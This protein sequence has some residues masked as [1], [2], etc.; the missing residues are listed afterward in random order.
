[1]STSVADN[2]NC[3]HYEWSTEINV[4]KQIL[5]NATLLSRMTEN[6]GSM[7]RQQK[8]PPASLVLT[9]LADKGKKS[10]NYIVFLLPIGK[11]LLMSTERDGIFLTLLLMM[12]KW[13]RVFAVIK[14]CTVY[15]TSFANTNMEINLDWSYVQTVQ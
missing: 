2:G 10:K 7:I 12:G 11:S 15:T 6:K 3:I 8:Q 4:Y 1:M 5:I 13:I 9:E 14:T